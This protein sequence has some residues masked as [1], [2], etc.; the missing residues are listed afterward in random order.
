[1]RSISNALADAAG[2]RG[3]RWIH[4][5]AGSVRLSD[6]ARA[7]RL[8]TPAAPLSDRSVVLSVRDQL[9]AVLALIELDGLARR[10]V[11]CTPDITA[12]MLADIA[13]RTGAEAIVSDADAALDGLLHVRCTLPS[14]QP[15]SQPHSQPPSPAPSPLPQ[16]VTEWVLLTSG[17]AGAAKMVRHT[18]ATLTGAIGSAASE[19]PP[20]SGVVWGTFYDVRRYGGLQVVLRALVGGGSL[21]LGIAGE[22][23][24]DHIARLAAHG[25][26]HV[27]GTPSHWRRVLMS[28]NAGD[29]APR[30]IR[31]SGEVA[32]QPILDALA[33]RYP[34]ARLAHAFAST[35]AGVGFE[36]CDGLAGFPTTFVD[37]AGSVGI[38]VR[39]GS[40][41]LRSMRTALGYVDTA[42]GPLADADGFV[43][44]GDMVERR[45]D[46]YY[47]LGR[48]NGVI[49]VGGLKVHPEEVEAA[50]NRHPS[51][52]MSKVRSTPNPITGA[53]VAAEIVLDRAA[54]ADGSMRDILRMCRDTLA[55][56]KVPAVIRTVAALDL[57]PTGKQA[58]HGS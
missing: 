56:H 51:V 19:C 6:A 46:R 10:L 35:E 16:L 45:G 57:A 40:L 7:S 9:T 14:S 36:V 39:D 32:D 28:P 25:A 48:R 12:G 30:Y 26:T 13:L 15:H 38:R 11:L 44:T 42:D 27:S 24:A 43:D 22:P 50:I 33:A 53:L 5:A 31:L 49:N 17:T 55:P 47:F 23:I 4:G 21:V 2:D 37:A 41:R 18:F 54:D 3:G 58:R 29:L 8:A 20:A 1:M 34:G 52:R